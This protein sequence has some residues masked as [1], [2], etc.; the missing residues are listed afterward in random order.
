MKGLIDLI[1]NTCKDLFNFVST[2]LDFGV[3]GSIATTVGCLV[4]AILLIALIVK[5][6]KKAV[7]TVI[8]AILIIA[9]LV[10]TGMV[11]GTQIKN[12]VDQTRK[13]GF[14]SAT[15]E[16]T[17]DINFKDFVMDNR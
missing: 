4:V 9:I 14:A 17:D 10:C 11:S 8:T 3:E 15:E 6:V 2:T 7:G 1:V 16:I 5:F 12:F 13:E